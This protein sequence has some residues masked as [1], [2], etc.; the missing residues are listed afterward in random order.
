MYVT[1][2]KTKYEAKQWWLQF[3]FS[4]L[5]D[6]S[7]MLMLKEDNMWQG[8][9]LLSK[10][11]DHDWSGKIQSFWLL[12]D[13]W[14]YFP[15]QFCLLLWL[16]L[17]FRQLEMTELWLNSLAT[18]TSGWCHG[19]PE[20]GKILSWLSEKDPWILVLKMTRTGKEKRHLGQ[21][22]DAKGKSTGD[23][24]VKYSKMF[25]E[26]RWEKRWCNLGPAQ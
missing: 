17:T 20:H 4:P 15:D 5:K 13:R 11:P 14:R 18:Q 25:R 3:A 7:Q 16:V 19:C 21:M 23:Q 12:N 8:L 24:S 26:Q 9:S 10:W 22:G 2:F 1:Q 6:C